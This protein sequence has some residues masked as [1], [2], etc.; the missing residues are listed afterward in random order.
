MTSSFTWFLVGRIIHNYW[1]YITSSRAI[2]N[3]KWWVSAEW[4]LL[5]KY[6]HRRGP[7]DH[8]EREIAQCFQASLMC[9][10]VYCYP[11][12]SQTLEVTVSSYPWLSHAAFGLTLHFLFLSI[13]FFHDISK[14]KMSLQKLCHIKHVPSSKL[15]SLYPWMFSVLKNKL[16]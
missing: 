4:P 12:T 8:G 15:C 1:Y 14:T 7:P 11:W 13:F 5:I 9:V 6:R 2:V 16:I 10:Q 3:L